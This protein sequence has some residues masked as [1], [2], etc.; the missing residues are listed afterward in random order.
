MSGLAAILGGHHPAGVYQWHGAMP[1]AEVKHTVEHAG[2]DF[3]LVDG[4]THPDKAGLLA[5]LAAT[6][7]FPVWF[8]HNF[9][10]LADCLRDVT[11]PMVV[12]WDGWATL[13]RVDGNAF[14]AALD[15]FME[16]AGQTPPFA[17][18]LRGDGPEVD[19]PSLD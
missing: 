1:E 19:V 11:E 13:A 2:W 16:R 5:E 4:W 15:V 14:E 18:L 3:G 9:D 12:L 8:G 17:V 6:L 7:S 10:A